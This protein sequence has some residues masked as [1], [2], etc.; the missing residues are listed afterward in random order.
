MFVVWLHDKYAEMQIIKKKS[1]TNILTY[2]F[3]R[4]SFKIILNI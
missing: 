3:A 4:A 2:K 1:L